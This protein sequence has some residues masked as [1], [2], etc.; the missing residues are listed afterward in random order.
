MITQSKRIAGRRALL[1]I[2]EIHIRVSPATSPQINVPRPVGQR[3]VGVMPLVSTAGTVRADVNEG[4]RHLPGRG[5]VMMIRNAQRHTVAP[6]EAVYGLAIPALVP[7]L[8]GVATAPIEHVH[9]V[10]EARLIDREI[11]RELEED[12][13]AV[14]SE[15]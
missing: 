10:A 3:R 8:E 7:E 2:V 6:K 12:R 14:R 15:D 11:R 1:I 9:E 13:A 5:G 4:G